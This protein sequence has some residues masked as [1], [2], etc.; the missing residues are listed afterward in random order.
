MV[1]I[2]RFLLVKKC[3]SITCV[4]IE[5]LYDRLYEEFGRE[6]HL[7]WHAAITSFFANILQT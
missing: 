4:K 3:S 6:L 2:V 1:C 5:N 7:L